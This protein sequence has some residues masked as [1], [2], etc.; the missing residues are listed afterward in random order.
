[1]SRGTG[2]VTRDD[3]GWHPEHAT[4]P[5]GGSAA[6]T[7]AATKAAAIEASPIAAA[8]A[9]DITYT[10]VMPWCLRGTVRMRLPV[11]AKKALRTAG[12]ATQMVGSPTPPQ[13]P[14]DGMT[15]DSTF[16]IC[17]MR[18]ESYVLK[19]VCSTR[20]SLMVISSMKSADKP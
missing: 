19:L 8:T 16:G 10:S 5:A 15:I 2:D 9:F 3:V 17:L 14:P 7:A 18:I 12:A 11:A 1:M 20:P 6:A 4:A 13:N